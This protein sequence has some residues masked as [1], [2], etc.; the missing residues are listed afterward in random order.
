MEKSRKNGIASAPWDEQIYLVKSFSSTQP[1]TVKCNSHSGVLFKFSCDDMCQ[2]IFYSFLYWL[3]NC[4]LLLSSVITGSDL[5]AIAYSDLPSGF[6]RKGKRKREKKITQIDLLV[7]SA[8]KF[9]YCTMYFRI[10]FW[11]RAAVVNVS[12]GSVFTVSSHYMCMFKFL[13][14]C[15]YFICSPNFVLKFKN[16]G[17]SV[18]RKNYDGVIDTMQ[19]QQKER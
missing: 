3:V 10:Y 4:Y 15:M 2:R 6:G 19:Q 12:S 1:H 17:V 9:F 13:H 8:C 7:Q 14:L 5:S 18:L 11:E 16:K